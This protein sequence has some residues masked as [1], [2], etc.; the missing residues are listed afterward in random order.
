MNF[1]DILAFRYLSYYI[2]IETFHFAKA[3]FYTEN[4]F[5]C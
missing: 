1:L 2:S 3:I 4:L 5:L